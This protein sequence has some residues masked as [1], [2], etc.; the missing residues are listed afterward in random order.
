MEKARRGQIDRRSFLK[1][2][3]LLAALPLALR[4][5]VSFAADKPL[6]V[7]NWGGVAIRRSARPGP[8]A[9]PRPPAFR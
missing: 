1:G 3:G 9:S 2:M 5:G 6:V 7:V 4:S 8:R